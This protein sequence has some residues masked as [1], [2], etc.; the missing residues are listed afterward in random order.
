MAID[1]I[2]LAQDLIRCPSVTPKDAG[3]IAVLEAALKPLGFVC[4]RVRLQA[5]STEPIENL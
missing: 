4:H 5:P 3:A 1:A 2:P